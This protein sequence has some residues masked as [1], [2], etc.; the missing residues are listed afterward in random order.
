[1]LLKKPP[2]WEEGFLD[3][4]Q[5]STGRGNAC[6]IQ[7]PDGTN[8]LIDAGSINRDYT[9]KI[10]SVAV[11]DSSISPGF[12]I[13]EYIKQCI[14]SKFQV[15]IDH[16]LITHF[17]D[18]HAGYPDNASP[19]SKSGAYKLSG[20][21]E[22]GDQIPIKQLIDRGWPTYENISSVNKPIIENYL[23]FIREQQNRVGLIIDTFRLGPYK[24]FLKYNPG[25][26]NQ[27]LE[28][29]GWSVN[30]RY[31]NKDSSSAIPHSGKI[32]PAS[33]TFLFENNASC[34]IS[35]KYGDFTWF[36][37]GDLTSSEIGAKSPLNLEEKV[38]ESV[39]KVSVLVA[40]HHA[41]SDAVSNKTLE[42][43][44]PDYI[45]IPSWSYGHPSISSLNRIIAYNSQMT[46]LSTQVHPETWKEIM[47]GGLDKKIVQGGHL[48]IRVKGKGTRIERYL[49]IP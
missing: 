4:H 8:M 42:L 31:F 44:K 23:S 15:R 7:F 39:G 40:G 38:A 24:D 3:I 34:S 26:Y 32:I 17:H 37:G 47:Q 9:R 41:Y 43:M 6:F 14:T 22:V 28:I 12:M 27:T 33:D 46:I 21:T 5:L 49:I 13:S 2:V 10:A 30:G 48:M 19:W 1:M 25:K 16:A 29:T 45:V 18:D 36:T 11:P 35:I 20:I